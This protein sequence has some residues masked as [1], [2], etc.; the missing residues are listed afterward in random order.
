M[1]E[2]RCEITVKGMRAETWGFNED[3]QVTHKYGFLAWRERI[4]STHKTHN[5]GT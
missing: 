4:E 1:L 3:P 5:V 2:S